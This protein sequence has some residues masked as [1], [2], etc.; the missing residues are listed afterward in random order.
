MKP[1]CAPGTVAG[2]LPAEEGVYTLISLQGIRSLHWLAQA[3]V[4]SLMP[5][6]ILL[7][8]PPLYTVDSYLVYLVSSCELKYARK[9]KNNVPKL[10][11]QEAF[12]LSSLL[13]DFNFYLIYSDLM[14]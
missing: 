8:L 12:S 4:E 9:K 10:H 2:M 7:R 1:A 6:P 13:F 14:I 11:S 3:P 5:K